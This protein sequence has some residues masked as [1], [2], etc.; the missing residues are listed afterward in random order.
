MK[1]KSK[2]YKTKKK[3]CLVFQIFFPGIQPRKDVVAEK[4]IKYDDD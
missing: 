4:R 3:N 1:Q 2:N